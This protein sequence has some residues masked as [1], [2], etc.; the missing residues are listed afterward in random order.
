MYTLMLRAEKECHQVQQHRL[1]SGR[2]EGIDPH[3]DKTA[4]A[5]MDKFRKKV[6]DFGAESQMVG[7]RY[8]LVSST[9][10]I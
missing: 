1:T 2:V 6:I 8:D 4:E 7:S 9:M 10:V 5:V 3:R